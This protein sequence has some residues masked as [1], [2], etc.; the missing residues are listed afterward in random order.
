MATEND[1][2]DLILIGG[3]ITGAGVLRESAKKGLK[4]MLLEKNDFASGTSSKSA[5]LVHGGLRYLQHLQIKIVRE[6]L[7]ERNWLLESYPHLVKPI[8]FVFPLYGSAFKYRIAMALYQMMGKHKILPKYKFFDKKQTIKK[9]SGINTKELKGSFSY[10]DGITNDARLVSE[11]I[12]E[13]EQYPNIEAKNYIK[14]TN[15]EDKKNFSIVSCKNTL[16][17]E[18]FSFKTK[19]VVNCTGAW[20]DKTLEIFQ[21][22]SQKIMDPSKGV[23]LIFSQEKLPITSAYAFSSGTNDGRML[24][25]LPWENNTVILGPTDTAFNGDFDKLTSNKNDIQYLLNGLNQF[26]P[27]S[28]FTED[29]ILYLF[30]GLRPLFNEEGESKDKTRDFKIWWSS[31]NIVSISGGK[32]TTFRAMGKTLINKVLTKKQLTTSYHSFPK[33]ENISKDLPIRIKENYSKLAQIKLAKIISE[34]EQNIEQIIPELDFLKAEIIF[35]IKHLQ[36]KTIED[37]MIRRF[38]FDYGL[39]K[40]DYYKKLKDNIEILMQ[41]YI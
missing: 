28:N 6:S 10:Y 26:S 1:I 4:T 14:V 40:K 13:A 21:A 20:A 8:E 17:G 35:A 12:F 23:H 16:T 11:I 19:V 25:L 41:D 30:V 36:A 33:I 29:D 34:N 22:Q 2:Y 7:T 18:S 31:D 38:S 37:I 24:Y 3:G 27:N 5:K 39:Q 15:I 32:L 9:Y